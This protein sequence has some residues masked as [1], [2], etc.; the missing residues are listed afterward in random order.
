VDVLYPKIGN[1]MP[2]FD[3]FETLTQK[4]SKSFDSFMSCFYRDIITPFQVLD[5]SDHIS[6]FF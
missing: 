1:H 4:V 5:F 3:K 2:K 6:I